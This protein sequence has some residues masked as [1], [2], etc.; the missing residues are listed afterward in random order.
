[1]VTEKNNINNH[2]ETIP[3]KMVT[4]NELA[5]RTNVSAYGIRKLVRENKITYFKSGTKVLINYD[6]FIDFLNGE[7]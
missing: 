6:R 3:P 5:R 1:M 2:S 7:Q 4:V